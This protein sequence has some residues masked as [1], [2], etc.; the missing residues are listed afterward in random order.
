MH[1]QEFL[2]T[3]TRHDWPH[4]YSSDP[5]ASN[6]PVASVWSVLDLYP[7]G[8]GKQTHQPQTVN[9]RYWLV[10]GSYTI[11]YMEISEGSL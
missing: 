1:S 7:A 5:E 8:G 3:D 4:G 2:S 10:Y 9:M 11:G 6:G